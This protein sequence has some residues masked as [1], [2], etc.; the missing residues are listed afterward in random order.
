MTSFREARDVNFLSYDQG[1][2]SDD[3][4]LLLDDLYKPQ[5]LDF[6]YNLYTAS[7]LS[8]GYEI[9]KWQKAGKRVITGKPEAS[10]TFLIKQKTIYDRI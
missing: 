9:L 10:N 2:I 3:K 7:D 5:N 4:F 1:L 8:W 6:P